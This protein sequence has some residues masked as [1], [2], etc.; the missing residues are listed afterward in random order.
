MEFKGKP[1]LTVVNGQIKM[2][3][4]KILGDPSGQPL[5]F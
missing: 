5:V 4:G 1:V 3:D 2:K